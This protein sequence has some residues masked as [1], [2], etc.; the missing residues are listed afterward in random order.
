MESAIFGEV[1]MSVFVA[2]AIFDEVGVG[3]SLFVA[4][5]GE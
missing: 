5:S 3:V 4:G 2:G 1:G